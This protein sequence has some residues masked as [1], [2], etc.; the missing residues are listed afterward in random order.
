MKRIADYFRGIF[1]KYASPVFLVFLVLAFVLWYLT[2]LSYTY[3]TD[4]PV[5]VQVEGLRFRVPC[6]VEGPGYTLLAHR[7]YKRSSVT[8]RMSEL[9]TMPAPDDPGAILITPASLQSAI[10]ARNGD[11]RILSVGPIPLIPRN[12]LPQK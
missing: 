8:V 6:L 5:S 11:I 4:I 10:A 3:K 1:K 7:F 9:D 12:E 2:K